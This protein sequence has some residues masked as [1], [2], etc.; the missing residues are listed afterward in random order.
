MVVIK[1]FKMMQELELADITLDAIQS[2][3][4]NKH[5]INLFVYKYI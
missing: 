4:H 5:D 2:N 3:Q 1:D